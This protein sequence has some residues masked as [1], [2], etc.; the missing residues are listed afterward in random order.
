MLFTED[1]SIYPEKPT[2]LTGELLESEPSKNAGWRTTN[3]RSI[4]LRTVR[5]VKSAS[6]QRTTT[7][8][9]HLSEENGLTKAVRAVDGGTGGW[10]R[11]SVS[12]DRA[13]AWRDGKF[14]RRTL[15]WLHNSV[16][17]PRAPELCARKG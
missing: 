12:W 9:P 13:S 1:V 3:T 8:W 10:V 7:V 15:G 16:N 5:C 14:W 11:V 2:E 6:R 17:V 4:I